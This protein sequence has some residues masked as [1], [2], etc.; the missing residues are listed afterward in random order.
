MAI[1]HRQGM[2]LAVLFV[3][4]DRFKQVN[5]LLGHAIGDAL[6][7]S[8]TARLLG[9]VRGSDTVSRHGG[10]EFV[11]LV[12]H[13]QQSADAALVA[14]K[15]IDAL[16]A[17]HE[18]AGHVLHIT[19]SIGISIYPDDGAEA[20]ALISAADAAMYSAKANGPNT[21]EFFTASMNARRIAR[22]SLE[23]GLR[24]AIRDGQFI[25][26]YQPKF[27]IDTLRL[28]GAE[29]L[30]RWQHPTQGLLAPGAF[31]AVAEECGLIGAIGRW[32]L[33]EACRQACAWWS[34]GLSPTR[35][36]LN[37]SAVEFRAKDFLENVKAVLHE[38]GLAASWL[39]LEVTESVLMGD[40]ASTRDA[41]F[42]LRNLGV[43]L[44]IDDFG[45]GYSSLSYLSRFPI[46]CLKIDQSFVHGMMTE[47][48][49]A[50]I[51]TAVI[52]MGRSLNH[53]VLA[54]GVETAE[55]LA[56]L[57]R[58]SCAQGQGFYYSRPI[59][60]DQFADLLR[61]EPAM[62]DSGMSGVQ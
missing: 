35:M 37:V 15:I 34:E 1:A 59:A 2:R 18:I 58:L 3:D 31:I 61:R 16:A 55:Q 43:H 13:I 48:H 30:I 40:T 11:V 12:F 39:E 4:L 52:A 20:E 42:A 19:A 33:R 28:T 6:L 21:S 62:A 32:A 10:D 36:A 51:I 54:E 56:V 27:A 26:H 17:P 44:A 38:T 53:T 57:Q 8:V 41:L 24:S 29:A 45:T 50:A 9:A 60:P 47:A 5:D 14:E 49:D 46:N 22:R 25:L 23:G 7:K